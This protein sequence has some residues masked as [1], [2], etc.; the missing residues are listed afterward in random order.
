MEIKQLQQQIHQQNVDAG[1]WDSYR[2]DAAL[3]NLM[4]SEISEA[5]EGLRKGLMD[6]HL[7]QYEMAL[8]ELAD[9]VIRCLDWL[10][11]KKLSSAEY[12]FDGIEL[13]RLCELPEVEMDIQ[14][15][16]ATI[17]AKL[18]AAY[19]RK[20]ERAYFICMAMRL[21][22]LTIEQFYPNYSP[23]VIVLEKLE[24]NKNRADHKREN[25]AKAH[26]KQF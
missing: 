22:L 14:E 20:E 16:L 11:Y 13:H 18:S 5:L 3:I 26:G 10:G 1:W 24:Y 8:V 7:P 4:H 25:R 6:N 19:S 17:H 9:C 15:A 23:E 21:C 12:K 2:S